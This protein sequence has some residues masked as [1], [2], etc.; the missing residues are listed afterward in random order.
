[1]FVN[2]KF[3]GRLVALCTVALLVLSCSAGAQ[4]LLPSESADAPPPVDVQSLMQQ[5]NDALAQEDYEQA[6]K[7]FSE[8]IQAGTTDA[9]AYAAL[10]EAHTNRGRALAGLKEYEAALA[11]FK[12]ILDANENYVP[13]LVARGQMYLDINDPTDALADFQAAA[14][15]DRNNMD[16][17]FGL[18][19]SYVL[20]GG[21][22][23]PQAVKPLTKVIEADPQNAEAYRLRGTAYGAMYK[24]DKSYADLNQAISLNP[25]DYEAYYTLALV[26]RQQ[27]QYA[28]AIKN[29]DLAIEHFVP[30]EDAELQF[31]I[32]GY[33]LK[34]L[35]ASSW[36]T[37]FDDGAEQQL[38]YQES[39]DTCDKALELLGDSP[40]RAQWRSMMLHNRGVA[41][42]MLGELNLAIEA[43]ADAFELNPDLGETYFRRGICYEALGE[44]KMAAA[45]FSRRP[46]ST[47]TT[48][49]RGCGK[50]W[51]TPRWRITTR[52]WRPT[53]GPSRS[54]TAT[55]WPTST[56]V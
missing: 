24:T 44:E 17:L 32:E 34:A 35:W 15:V 28:E 50:G 10:P 46:R 55:R 42:R 38:A 6:V 36:A 51:L 30:E 52:R 37:R 19:K 54:A 33:R 9:Q 43:F 12:E 48:P 56:A 41:L 13:A 11:D 5:G 2:R 16:V 47:T 27:E 1:M 18:G 4:D 21:Q 7:A 45:D 14:K 39:L 29:V 26:Q 25:D 20:L 3:V 22:Y 49:A 40:L 31:Y 23:L 53:A 8:V